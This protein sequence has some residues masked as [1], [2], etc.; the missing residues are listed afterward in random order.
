MFDA[1]QKW[2]LIVCAGVIVVGLAIL[3]FDRYVVRGDQSSTP[4]RSAS[5]L[6][7]VAS[8]LQMQPIDS[9]AERLGLLRLLQ[10]QPELVGRD[11]TIEAVL[12]RRFDG[13]TLTAIDFSSQTA[14]MYGAQGTRHDVAVGHLAI[15]LQ[16]DAGS[17]LPDWSTLSGEPAP[18]PPFTV[19]ALARLA[20]MDEFEMASSERQLIFVSRADGWALMRAAERSTSAEFQPGLL[21]SALRIDLQRAIDVLN[22][23]ELGLAGLPP[24]YE[25][26]VDPRIEVNL[27]TG[28]SERLEKVRLDAEAQRLQLKETLEEQSRANQAARDALAAEREARQQEQREKQRLA[29][30]RLKRQGDEARARA[31]AAADPTA[32]KSEPDKD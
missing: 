22:A 32:P 10:Q 11:P 25:I 23:L 13:A 26:K 20:A 2:T 7:D 18:A 15:L 17:A 1:S 31:A 12:Q 29:I 14:G 16:L 4:P 21:N 6:D 5:T 24:I 30:E 9:A 19:G 8:T 27:D 3:A 28:I